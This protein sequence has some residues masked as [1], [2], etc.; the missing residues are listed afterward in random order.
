MK[1][2]LKYTKNKY[3][4]EADEILFADNH[5]DADCDLYR[6]ECVP[7]RA[8]KADLFFCVYQSVPDL[9]AHDAQLPAQGL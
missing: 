6:E 1:Y 7:V 2:C 4:Q 3:I 5:G 8:V 9:G